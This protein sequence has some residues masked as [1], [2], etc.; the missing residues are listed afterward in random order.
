MSGLNTFH[1]LELW[2]AA[3]CTLGIYSILYR[4]NV[5]FRFLEHLYVGLAMGYLVFTAWAM[6]LEPLWW[7]PMVKEL[8]WT[9][10]FAL[11]AGTLWYLI[12]S[13]RY[14][15][16]SRLIIMTALGVASGY[17]FNWF[18]NLVIPQLSAAIE[19]PLY[20]QGALQ[21]S[22]IIAAIT[23][24][25]VLVYF[26]FSFEQKSRVVQGT[27]A[28]GRWLMMVAFGAMFGT[29]VMARVSL[30]IGRLQFLMGDWLGILRP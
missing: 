8:K 24:I 3:L 21:I 16:M 7:K 9:W 20:H 4:E 18:A 13:R 5:V 10:A 1:G 11:P 29:T 15:W 28:T 17:A 25:C 2:V 23:L 12:Y 6:V 14:V 22:N 30:F 19:R 27:A 26:F